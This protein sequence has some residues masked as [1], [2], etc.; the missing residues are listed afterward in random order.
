MW[1][2]LEIRNHKE[3]GFKVLYMSNLIFGNVEESLRLI[4]LYKSV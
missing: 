3:F 2:V 1:F 4:I